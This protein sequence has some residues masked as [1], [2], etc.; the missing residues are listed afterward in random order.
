MRGCFVIETSECHKNPCPYMVP[1]IDRIN[2]RKCGCK[3]STLGLC[4]YMSVHVCTCQYMSVYVSTCLYMS[5]HVCTCLYMSVYVCICLYMSVYVSTC[6][7]MSVHVCTC[8]YMSVYVSRSG[9]TSK[10]WFTSPTWSLPL[11]IITTT[12]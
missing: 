1:C 11:I 2:S 6:L 3:G 8:Q 9:V 12:N 4:Q 5:A 10:V 7:Y